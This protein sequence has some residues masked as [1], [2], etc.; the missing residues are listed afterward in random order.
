MPKRVKY[1]AGTLEE[2]NGEQEY[3]H[4][5]IIEAVSVRQ[6]Q[7]ILNDYAKTFYNG[8]P[9]KGDD[10]YYFFNG[11]LWVGARDVVRTS[12]AAWQR[13]QLRICLLKKTGK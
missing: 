10:G 12:M 11:Q 7:S 4:D 8:K 3:S 13:Q 6:A 2:R 5:Y 1:Y 9:E